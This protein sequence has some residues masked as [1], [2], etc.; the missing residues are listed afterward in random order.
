MGDNIDQTSLMNALQV[1]G[2]AGG[3]DPGSIPGDE[4]QNGEKTADGTAVID[5]PSKN[6]ISGQGKAKGQLALSAY[7]ASSK[8]RPSSSSAAKKS[9]AEVA[10]GHHSLNL[11]DRLTQQLVAGQAECMVCLEKI[12]PKN[13]TWHCDGEC[14]QVFHIHC[15]KKWS[16]I[17]RTEDGG[18]RCPGCQ[19]VRKTVPREYRCF[20]GKVVDPPYER[21]RETPHSCG[22]MCG[23]TLKTATNVQCKHKCVELCHPGPCPPCV[24]SV[25]Q[26]CPCG[27][28]SQNGRCGTT[29]ICENVCGRL[30]NCRVHRCQQKCHKDACE[31]CTVKITQKCACSEPSENVVDCDIS[32]LE[33]GYSCEKICNKKLSCG[34]HNCSKICHDPKI[35]PNCEI[36]P[37]SP[38][39][40]KTCHCG[41][42]PLEENSRQICTD[43]IPSCGEI[44]DKTL[45]CGPVGAN[46]KCQDICHPGACPKCPLT[47][48][49][50]CRCG[51][52]DKEMDCSK[53]SSRA[54]D[55][56]CEKQCSKKRDCLRHKCG[57][58]CCILL[59]H[60]CPLVCGRLLSCGRHRCSEPCHRGNCSTS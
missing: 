40:I 46:H 29:P 49:V 22:E 35:D 36:C 53:L 6:V 5:E 38:E 14:F 43:P 21:G 11:K 27:Q 3:L 34:N 56:R 39:L 55:A 60:V 4:T 54:D 31:P 28:T 1:P 41:K 44:C 10:G 59:D 8:K 20:C 7:Q 45:L 9:S 48:E 37:Q 16:K 2:D 30:L 24:A 23:K 18:W 57:Q 58:K 52:M 26:T 25:L 19:F 32:V 42:L 13:A 15:I 51:F 12:R 33:T 47:T 17:A 50:K